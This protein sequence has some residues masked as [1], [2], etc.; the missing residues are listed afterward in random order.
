MSA[1]VPN[2]P[3]AVPVTD[4]TGR[5]AAVWSRWITLLYLRIGTADAL[6][7]TELAALHDE[8]LTALQTQ[9]N[10]LSSTVTALQIQMT[11]GLQSLGVGPVL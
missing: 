10:T 3:L 1:A 7:N 8:S 4:S 2:P 6:S 9:V 5:L 11:I